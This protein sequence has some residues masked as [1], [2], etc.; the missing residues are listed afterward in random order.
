MQKNKKL[1]LGKE[2]FKSLTPDQ[3][4]EVAGGNAP[5]NTVLTR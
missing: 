1:K 2:T 5:D 4:N 3:L